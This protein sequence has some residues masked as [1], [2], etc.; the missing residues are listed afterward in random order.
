MKAVVAQKP[1]CR[2]CGATLERSLSRCP[3][4]GRRS[5]FGLLLPRWLRI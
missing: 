5:L 1:A 3:R 2:R 4:C